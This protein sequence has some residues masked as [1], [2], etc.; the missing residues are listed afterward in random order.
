[1]R[2]SVLAGTYS[3]FRREDETKIYCTAKK[4]TVP[5]FSISVSV[6]ELNQPRL[7]IKAQPSSKTE[8]SL[9]APQVVSILPA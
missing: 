3:N 5:Q 4:Q 1:M 2:P 7:I 9:S 8:N 6:H